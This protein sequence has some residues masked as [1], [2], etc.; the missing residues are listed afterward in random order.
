MQCRR[1]DY[2]QKTKERN[3][4][5]KTELIHA[6]YNNANTCA[7]RTTIARV[8]DSLATVVHEELAN[9]GEVTLPGLVKFTRTERAERQG[10]NPKTG[11]AIT[12]PAALVPKV[13][14]LKVFKD[15]VY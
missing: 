3:N 9:D 12:I 13:K 1:A 10:R 6:I 8:L 5:N 2:R 7:S 14:V 4:M 11:E 15:N